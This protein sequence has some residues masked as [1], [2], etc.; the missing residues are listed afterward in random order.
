MSGCAA[1]QVL[2]LKLGRHSKR[3]KL[4]HRIGEYWLRLLHTEE[5]DIIR[6]CY[7][8]Q[9]RDFMRAEL[10]TQRKEQKTRDYIYLAKP[11]KNQYKQALYNRPI[12]ETGSNIERQ[13][14]FVG[15]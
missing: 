4:R 12:K 13:G 2:K 1:N 8:W 10:R 15:Y 14:L 11:C 3:R 5:Q 9:I 7:E 6:M